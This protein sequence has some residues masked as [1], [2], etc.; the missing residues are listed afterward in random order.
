LKLATIDPAT[1]NV[2]ILSDQVISNDGFSMGDCDID[3][4]NNRYLYVRQD[5]LYTVNLTDGSLINKMKIENINSAITPLT[6][7][8][9]DDLTEAPVGF[10]SKEMG[11]TMQILPG[12]TLSLNAWV[13]DDVSYEWQDGSTNST[14]WVTETG[15]YQ[16]TIKRG[17]FAIIGTVTVEAGTVVSTG[18]VEEELGVN[19]FPNP[20]QEVIYFELEN[21]NGVQNE[22]ELLDING[23]SI[24]SK[25]ITASVGNIKISNLAT[26]IYILR[27]YQNGKV[28]QRRAVID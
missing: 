5:S 6:S 20:A 19:I 18:D 2:N 11:E 12:E 17:G 26:G 9:Y 15:E 10:I 4:T 23:K 13:G 24:L 14:L 8:V 28:A 25:N 22:L 7:I 21:F 16:V 1:G 3:P 27:F